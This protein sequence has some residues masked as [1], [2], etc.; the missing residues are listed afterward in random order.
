MYMYTGAGFKK[1]KVIHYFWVVAWQLQRGHT[2][3]K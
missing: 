3:A 2:L 1:R